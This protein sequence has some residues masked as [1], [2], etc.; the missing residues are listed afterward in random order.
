MGVIFVNKKTILYLIGSFIFAFLLGELVHEYGHFM[1]HVLFGHEG[2]SVIIDPFGGSCNIGVTAM[3]NLEVAWT[4]IMGP[5]FNVLC[6]AVVYFLVRNQ[7]FLPLRI[8]FPI[9]LIQE[10][11]TFSIGNLTMGGDAYWIS[12]ST[13][14]HTLAILIF[15]IALL[16][17]GIWT[18]A[19]ELSA[20]PDLKH[21]NFIKKLITIF[22]SFG[23]LLIIRAFYSI[24]LNP[25]LIVEN[26][27]PLLFSIIVACVV[28]LLIRDS[29][30]DRPVTDKKANI[31]ITMGIAMFVFQLLI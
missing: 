11:V 26:L 1:M 23:A 22:L 12:A 19:R 30:I 4:T 15:G 10:G 31:A 21:L 5:M 14:I 3:P 6:A 24:V 9:A 2:I 17:L 18:L 16:C 13:G 27:V 29:G 25:S 8:W 20:I 28:S 7:F